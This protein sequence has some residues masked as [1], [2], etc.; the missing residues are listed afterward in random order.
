MIVQLPFC[1]DHGWLTPLCLVVALDAGV[2]VQIFPTYGWFLSGRRA[3]KTSCP[4][5]PLSINPLDQDPTHPLDHYS[6]FNR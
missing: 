3:S 6:V 2:F 1:S 4:P 5:P